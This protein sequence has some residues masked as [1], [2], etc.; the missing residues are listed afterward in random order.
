MCRSKE[1]VK[2]KHNQWNKTD[3]K[4]GKVHFWQYLKI[5][6]QENGLRRAIGE[7][8][9]DW[10]ALM[11]IQMTDAGGRLEWNNKEREKLLMSAYKDH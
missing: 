6:D 8:Q 9:R 4:T 10:K 1:I 2:E 3:E 11:V 5:H 7:N